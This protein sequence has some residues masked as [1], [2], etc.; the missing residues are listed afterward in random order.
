[1]AIIPFKLGLYCECYTYLFTTQ[2][3]Q[4]S[5]LSLGEESYKSADVFVTRKTQTS[6]YLVHCYQSHHVLVWHVSQNAHQTLVHKKCQFLAHAVEYLQFKIF[7][8]FFPFLF[9][10]YCRTKTANLSTFQLRIL[11]KNLIDFYIGRSSS[12]Y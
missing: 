1:M 2:F 7:P 10:S 4:S 11:Q 5:C 12:F 6:Q 8:S 9:S 3:V